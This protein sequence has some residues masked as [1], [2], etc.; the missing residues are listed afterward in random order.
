MALSFLERLCHAI[1]CMTP[2]DPQRRGRFIVLE[3]PDGCGTTMHASLLADALTKD[4]TVFRTAEPTP[5]PIGKAIRG[6]L[7]EAQIPSDTLQLLFTADRAWHV[8]QEVL[9]ALEEGTCVISDRYSL[10]TLAYGEAT[11][12]DVD[13]L[14]DMNKK[15]VRPD[16]TILLLAPVDVCMERIA[17]RGA[18]DLMERR[19]LQEAVHAAY[20]RLASGRPDITIIESNRP[21]ADVAAD[22]L[23]AVRP[24]LR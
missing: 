24:V 23:A 1:Q 21:I 6:F 17:A 20:R 18:H 15:F 13:W 9:P 2:A 4:R 11:G 19:A 12:V 5:G 22:V 14:E 8:A 16:C 3:G 7:K 10:S